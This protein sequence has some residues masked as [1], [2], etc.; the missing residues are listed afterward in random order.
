MAVWTPIQ[1]NHTHRTRSSWQ[2]T[3][4][5]THAFIH[6]AKSYTFFFFLNHPHNQTHTDLRILLAQPSVLLCL[7]TESPWVAEAL[8]EDPVHLAATPSYGTRTT[9]LGSTSSNMPVLTT[10]WPYLWPQHCARYDW[11]TVKYGVTAS[12]WSMPLLIATT[13]PI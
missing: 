1:S 8:A 2:H 10:R 5:D 4:F 6:E 12:T 11:S 13:W 7:G 9:G 3:H